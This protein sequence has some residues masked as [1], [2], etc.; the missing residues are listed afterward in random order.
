MPIR[1]ASNPQSKSVAKALLAIG[2]RNQSKD[3]DL[4]AQKLIEWT[5][6]NKEDA[7]HLW[8]L[9]ESGQIEA[10]KGGVIPMAD[11][12]DPKLD[13]KILS[14]VHTWGQIQ[15]QDKRTALVSNRV[16]TRTNLKT[17]GTNDPKVVD[18]LFDFVCGTED[19]RPI[20][21]G[22]SHG[23]LQM[24][25]TARIRAC[26]RVGKVVL[27]PDGTV[28]YDRTTVFKLGEDHEG[29]ITMYHNFAED[30]SVLLTLF[31]YR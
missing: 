17:L 12:K 28:D 24:D 31:I 15:Q 10:L 21:P 30:A 7:V 25:I 4:P 8:R 1:G 26:G 20:P 11:S 2:E 19:D 9:V 18:K 5:K 6:K 29:I 3:A 27:S 14:R 16:V 13:K 23:D 22:Y